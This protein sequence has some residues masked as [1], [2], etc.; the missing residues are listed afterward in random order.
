MDDVSGQQGRSALITGGASG[1]G[2]AIARRLAGLGVTV[3]IADLDLAGA[4]AVAAETGGNAWQLDLSD[5]AALSG[6]ALEVDILVNNAGVQRV[7]PIEEMDPELFHQ[8]LMIMVEAPFRLIRS[9]L[10]YMYAQGYGRIVNVSSV[11][12][13]RASAYKSAYVTAKHAL[14][15]LSKVT[16][17]EGGPHGVTSNCINPGYVRTPL[18]EKQVADQARIHRLEQSAVLE[19]VMLA[20]NA[21]KRLVEPEE[22]AALVAWLVGPEAAMVTGASYTMDG[23]WTAQ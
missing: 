23:G 2:A 14:E 3:Q 11:H 17:L 9:A 19:E 22:V 20:H 1:I 12:G 5:P 18:V 4:Q 8:M 6:I 16:A 10:P 21:I 15:G 7:S 13:L